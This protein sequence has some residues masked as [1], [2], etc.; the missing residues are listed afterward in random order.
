M[1]PG[2]VS[3]QLREE[4][5][6]FQAPPCLPGFWVAAS[7]MAPGVGQGRG[8]GKPSVGW[9]GQCCCRN[10]AGGGE[11]SCSPHTLAGQRL[12]YGW[13]ILANALC[14]GC[15]NLGGGGWRKPCSPWIPL[16]GA[17][18]FGLFLPQPFSSFL[19]SFNTQTPDFEISHP[20]PMIL[21]QKHWG[22]LRLVGGP[23]GRG[24]AESS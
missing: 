15:W 10:A 19:F 7:D 13:L 9:G 14:Y 18:H 22:A 4:G 1:A 23:R 12:A 3:Q 2:A 11:D 8:T 24:A 20:T 5:P 16:A 17:E 6:P 21:S